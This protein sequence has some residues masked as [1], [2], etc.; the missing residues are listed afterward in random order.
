MRDST[1]D[2]VEKRLISV[3]EAAR[4]LGEPEHRIRDI[5]KRNLVPSGMVGGSYVIDSNRLPEIRNVLERSTARGQTKRFIRN[6][7]WRP[8]AYWR[9]HQDMF[10]LVLAFIAIVGFLRS[11]IP[12]NVIWTGII[13]IFNAVCVLLR[14]QSDSRSS[15]PMPRHPPITGSTKPVNGGNL[16]TAQMLIAAIS[17]AI[18]LLS[19]WPDAPL[20]ISDIDPTATATAMATA[21]VIPTAT[22]WPTLTPTPVPTE[23]PV[24]TPTEGPPPPTDEPLPEAC[25]DVDLPPCPAPQVDP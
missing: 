5:L 10:N 20:A 14:Q 16:F 11:F 25:G 3:P 19:F 13:S 6:L 22:A 21:T 7:T 18:M 17:I 12:I 23:T 4:L 8:L 1:P 24:P 15:S 2:N 9:R